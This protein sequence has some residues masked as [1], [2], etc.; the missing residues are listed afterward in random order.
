MLVNTCHGPRA[1][2]QAICTEVSNAA[3]VHNPISTSNLYAAVQVFG[4]FAVVATAT[5]CL[6]FMDVSKVASTAGLEAVGV[7][8][9][10]L[11]LLYIVATVIL[12][13]KFGAEKAQQILHSVSSKAPAAAKML[14]RPL[15]SGLQRL[16]TLPLMPAFLR[17]DTGMSAGGDAT[18]P[19]SDVTNSAA[20][21]FSNGWLHRRPA[22]VGRT[23][24]S[25]L[26]LLSLTDAVGSPTGAPRHAQP[27][28]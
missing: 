9:L 15:S 25:Q 21:S 19:N 16:T 3:C 22:S 7:L 6:Y 17:R 14:L 28:S 27:Q 8:L 24:S 11:N 18:L 5:G 10:V 4:K 12:V 2:A 13:T 1:A 26:V 23:S 20:S